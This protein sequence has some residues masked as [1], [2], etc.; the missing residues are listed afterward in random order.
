ME[1]QNERRRRVGDKGGRK[2]KEKS[3][4]QDARK[5]KAKVKK[6]EAKQP[7]GKTIHET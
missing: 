7:K 5:Q 6:K 3:Q 2:D 4:K 1:E